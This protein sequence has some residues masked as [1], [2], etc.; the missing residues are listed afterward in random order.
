MGWRSS[1]GPSL[2]EWLAALARPRTEAE[3]QEDEERYY[4]EAA[5]AWVARGGRVVRC[6]S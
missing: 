4:A 3:I 1:T 2:T 6:A 5:R